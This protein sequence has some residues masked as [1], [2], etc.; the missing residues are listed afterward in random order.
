MI[1]LGNNIT[2]A[3]DALQRVKVSSVALAIRNP[4]PDVVARVRQLRIIRNLDDKQYSVLKRQLPYLVCGNFNPC[5][6]RTENFAFIEYFFLDVDHLSQKNLSLASVRSAVQA[7]SRVV[8]AFV[9][10]SE[11]GVKLLFKLSERCYDAG[12]FSQFYRSFALQFSKQYGFDQAL[13]ARTCDVTRACFVSVDPDCYYNPSADTVSLDAFVATDN[14]MQFFS[15]K[16]AIEQEISNMQH[17]DPPQPKQDVSQEVMDNIRAILNP[18]QKAKEERVVY[19][20]RQIEEVMTDLTAY[21]TKTG[22]EVTEI[23]NIQY[24]KKIRT[25]LSVKEAETNVFYGKRGFSVVVSPRRGTNA[26]LGELVAE[27]IQSFFDTY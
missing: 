7:D 11:D 22:L 8:M 6:R 18:K 3:Y 14:A 9:S 21:I 5:F 25:R 27:L 1:F 20:P 12:I 26:E 13:D 23:I 15:D 4:K 17:L 10:P 16:R 19:V 24:G 2:S